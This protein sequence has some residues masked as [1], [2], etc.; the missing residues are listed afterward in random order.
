MAE[1]HP[2][3]LMAVKRILCYVVGSQCHGVL[4]ERARPG[5]LLLLGYSDSDHAGDIED[6]QSPSGHSFY[7]GGSPIS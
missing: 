6:S 5:E 2:D 3:H 7:P 4:Y 1:P